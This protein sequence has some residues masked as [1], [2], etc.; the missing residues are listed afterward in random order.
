MRVKKMAAGESRVRGNGR[1]RRREYRDRQAW[2]AIIDAQ[3]KSGQ[4]VQA[5]CAERALA[6][7]TF[8]TWRKRLWT[9]KS[10]LVCRPEPDFL[11]VPIRSAMSMGT[12]IEVEVGQ[13][14]LRLDAVAGA[15]VVEAIVARVALGEVRP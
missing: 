3:K 7:S 6:Q 8:W 4:S 15:R 12:G 13:M 11:A 1:A 2:E 14:R 5:F 9:G 10:A